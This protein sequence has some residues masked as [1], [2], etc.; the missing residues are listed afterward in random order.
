MAIALPSKLGG[1]PLTFG[2]GSGWEGAGV[3]GCGND[4]GVRFL[5]LPL[6]L[7]VVWYVWGVMAVGAW[8]AEVVDGCPG[9]NVHPAVSKHRKNMHRDLR[10]G[11]VGLTGSM[12]GLVSRGL[13]GN[14]NSPIRYI[15]T[16]DAVNHITR[17]TTYT[18]GFRHRNINSAVAIASY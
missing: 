8:E 7:R 4:S 11:A 16:S 14:S 5:S 18:R 6:Y 3:G 1:R 15:V 9:V 2:F 12:T 10:R 13:H 17:D